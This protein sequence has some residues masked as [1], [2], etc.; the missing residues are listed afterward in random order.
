MQNSDEQRQQERRIVLPAEFSLGNYQWR[1]S[2]SLRLRPGPSGEDMESL[3]ANWI[4]EVRYA[5]GDGSFGVFGVLHDTGPVET[6]HY[7]ILVAGLLRHSATERAAWI[8][9]WEEIAGAAKI[10]TAKVGIAETMLQGAQA[11]GSDRVVV[12]FEA[13][14]NV[15]ADF[16]LLVGK[17]PA[18]LK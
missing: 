17:A 2:C 9:R 10:E 18:S 13:R 6:W 7:E 16:V 14:G 15:D 3:F 11:S 5:L 8:A 1:W 4:A 12:G